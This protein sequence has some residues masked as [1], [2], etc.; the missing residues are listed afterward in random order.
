MGCRFV[1]RRLVALVARDHE[2]DA[3]ASATP[4]GLQNVDG[5]HDV[6]RIG[7]DRVPITLAHQGLGRH[8]DHDL[9]SVLDHGLLHGRQIADIAIDIDH[10]FGK[11]GDVEK[12]SCLAR[13]KAEADDPGAERQQPQRQPCALEASVPRDQNG[14]VAPEICRHHGSEAFSSRGDVYYPTFCG[15]STVPVCPSIVNGQAMR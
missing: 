13:A 14:L 6:R 5:A 9:R 1:D 4:R 2:D 12:A 8:V 11:P 3:R 10:E 15:E 7:L